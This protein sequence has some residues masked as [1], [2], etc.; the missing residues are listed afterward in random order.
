MRRLTKPD[1]TGISLLLVLT[2][3][4]PAFM[5]FGY[6]TPYQLSTQSRRAVV[7]ATLLLVFTLSLVL[8]LRGRLPKAETPFLA[9]R[10][11]S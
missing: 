7:L 2:E 8:K 10:L 5:L 6:S 9:L 1:E 3:R 4:M 11:E